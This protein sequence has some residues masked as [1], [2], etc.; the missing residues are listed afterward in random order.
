MN[1]ILVV[2]DNADNR[3]SMRLLLSG[4]KVLEAAS[5]GEGI[6]LARKERPHCILLDVQMPDM[7]GFEVCRRLRADEET[8]SIPIILVTAHHRDTQSVVRG[9]AAGGDDYVSKPIAHQELLAR[10]RA[11]LRIGELQD[12]LEVL[13]V[14]LEDTVRKRTDELRQIYAT[15]PVGLYTLDGRGRIT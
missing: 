9:L 5:G 7:D 8:H 2:D 13:N 15:V 11:M 3:Y 10:V 1:R 12:R 14:E 6:E 4:Y